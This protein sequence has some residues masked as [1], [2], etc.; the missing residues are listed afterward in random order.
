[1]VEKEISGKAKISMDGSRILTI[2]MLPKSDICEEDAVEISKVAAE[3][4]Q[5]VVHCNLVD[6]SEMTFMDKK[7]RAAF[8]GTKKD[9]VL[10]VAIVSNSKIHRSLVNL[11]FGFSK[12]I[13][14]TKAFDNAEKARAWLLNKL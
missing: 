1:M 5:D 4:S 8:A 2:K 13:I 12:P 7:A 14:P 6:V 9:T 11:Y 10:A 3:I